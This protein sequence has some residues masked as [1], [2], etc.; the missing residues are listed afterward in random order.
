LFLIIIIDPDFREID[1]QLAIVTSKYQSLN[2]NKNDYIIITR[3]NNDPYLV[4][5]YKL[6]RPENKG[7]I[8]RTFFRIL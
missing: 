5:A 6:G 7:M 3:D 8:P 1:G 4:F 2:V